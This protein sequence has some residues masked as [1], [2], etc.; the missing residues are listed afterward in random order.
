MLYYSNYMRNFVKGKG[1]GRH[2]A[3]LKKLDRCV[4]GSDVFEKDFPFYIILANRIKLYV[5]TKCNNLTFIGSP[6]PPPAINLFMGVMS[7]NH[8]LK[9]VLRRWREWIH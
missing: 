1:D 2:A 5:Y 6:P 4:N 3:L 7:G 8:L 9:L